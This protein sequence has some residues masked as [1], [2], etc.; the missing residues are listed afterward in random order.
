MGEGEEKRE[1]RE[2][3]DARCVFFIVMTPRKKKRKKLYKPGYFCDELRFRQS[4]R[5]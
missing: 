2:D 4:L 1:P 3:L 5:G